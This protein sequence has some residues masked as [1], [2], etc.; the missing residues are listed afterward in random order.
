[1]G[2]VPVAVHFKLFDVLVQHGGPATAEEIANGANKLIQG[3]DEPQ[4]SDSSLNKM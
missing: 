2:F 4:I 1:L 3:K